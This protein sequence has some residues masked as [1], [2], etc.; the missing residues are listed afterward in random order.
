ME[1]TKI[2]TMEKLNQAYIKLI[3]MVL[4]GTYSSN[5]PYINSFYHDPSPEEA[6][7]L[8]NKIMNANVNEDG[9]AGKKEG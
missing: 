3:K 6:Y 4:N 5:T 1:N 7:N 8:L 9:T 2:L